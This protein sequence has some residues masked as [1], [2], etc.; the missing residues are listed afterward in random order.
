MHRYRITNTPSAMLDQVIHVTD[1]YFGVRVQ[2]LFV[3]C[4]A[5]V[6]TGPLFLNRGVPGTPQ[7]KR[8]NPGENT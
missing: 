6:L 7:A 5:N 4:P 8:Q 1:H 3:L 2:W